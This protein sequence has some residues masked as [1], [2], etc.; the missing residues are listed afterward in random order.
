[1]GKGLGIAA[2]VFTIFSIIVPAVAL[3]VLWLG[4]ALAVGAAFS[5]D[6]GLSIGAFAIGAVNIIFLS[7][8]TLA[9]VSAS[10]GLQIITGDLFLAIVAGRILA[11]NNTS[12]SGGTN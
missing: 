10:S 12:H 9:A 6:K 2:L 4:L 7:P 8:L 11:K 1:M 3:Y 5:G